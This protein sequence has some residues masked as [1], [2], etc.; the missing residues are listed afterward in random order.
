VVEQLHILTVLITSQAVDFTVFFGVAAGTERIRAGSG[1]YDR[2]NASVQ[3]GIFKPGNYA[4]DHLGGVRVILLGVIEPDPGHVKPFLHIA[5]RV[6]QGSFFIDDTGSVGI[7][8]PVRIRV[9]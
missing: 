1:K 8:P 5:F 3:G 6:C 4:F 9:Q 7:G 2:H